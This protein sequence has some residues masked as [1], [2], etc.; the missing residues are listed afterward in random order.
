MVKLSLQLWVMAND[1]PCRDI[2]VVMDT[3][4]LDDRPT[5]MCVFLNFNCCNQKSIAE[6]IGESMAYFWSLFIGTGIV[7]TFFMKYMYWY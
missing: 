3:W 4:L 1:Y 6:S 7:N 5:Y 2:I